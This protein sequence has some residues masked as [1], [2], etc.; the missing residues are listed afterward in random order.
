MKIDRF[1]IEPGKKVRIGKLRAD[2]TDGLKDQAEGEELLAKNSARLSEMQER[3]YAQ[4]IWGVLLIFQAMD[5]AGKDG[6]IKMVMSG[7]NP[8]G[9][10]VY[11]FK[12][13]SAE[14]LDHDFMWR[15]L[16]RMPQ[17][18]RIGIFNRSYYEEVLVVRVHPEFL[19]AQKLP[20]AAKKDVW[21]RRFEDIN[22]IERYLVNNG[23]LPIKFFLNVSKEEQ[24][25][26]FLKRID[27]PNK[28]WKFSENDVRERALWDR[29]MEAFE[30]MLEHTSTE[31]APWYAVPADHKWYTRAAVAE[32]IVQRLEALDL[33][34][35]EVSEARKRQL[36]KIRGALA[37]D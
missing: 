16:Q 20:P 28:N 2:D 10:E 23:I 17:R 15:Y 14:E 4:D 30:K 34:F 5:A 21:S 11:S 19:E 27:K 18:G 36:K 8:Q 24:L 12:A 37:K 33:R 35:P 29:Y 1:L 6:T 31:W 22:C 9:C 13:P 32:I 25:E 26:R 3:L 7:V